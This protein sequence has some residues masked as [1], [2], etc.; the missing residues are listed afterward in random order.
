MAIAQ[1]TQTDAPTL[2]DRT[3]RALGESMTVIN[4]NVPEFP[5]ID[6]EN[7]PGL[8]IVVTATGTYLV[9]IIEGTCTCPDMRWNSPNGGC[10]HVRRA[11]FATGAKAIPKEAVENDEIKID[12][13]LGRTVAGTA[14]TTH[15]GHP[16]LQKL[17]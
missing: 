10:K 11:R 13:M 1:Q 12:H 14:H 9:D 3:L 2:E 8:F 4:Q 16:P 15:D 6:V 17:I 7:S 5:N